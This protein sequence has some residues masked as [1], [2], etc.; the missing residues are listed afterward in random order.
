M[1]EDL[2]KAAVVSNVI[3]AGMLML[4]A[5]RALARRDFKLVALFLAAL[6]LTGY[7]TWIFAGQ[8]S[9]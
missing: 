1:T 5:K 7:A 6:T 2:A 8:M 3:F 4:S 9:Q